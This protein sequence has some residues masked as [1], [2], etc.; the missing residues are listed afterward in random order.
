MRRLARLVATCLLMLTTPVAAE[1]FP[2][3]TA[4]TVWQSGNSIGAFRAWDRLFPTRKVARGD[5]IRELAEGVPVTVSDFGTGKVSK[6]FATYI[7]RAR[8]TGLIVLKDGAVRFEGYWHGATRESRFV[9]HSLAKSVVS[10]LIGVAIGD[11]LIRSTADPITDYLPELKGT[12]YADVPIAAILEMSSGV[13]FTEEYDMDS[14]ADRIW[15]DTVVDR[16]TPITD[17][18]KSRKRER[19]PFAKFNYA[20]IETAALGMLLRKVTGKSVSAYLSEKLW[21]PLGMEDDASWGLDGEAETASEAAWCCLSARLRDY[22]RLGQLMLDDGV[23]DG[24]RLLP[25]GW[26]AEST[27]PNHEQVRHGRLYPDYGLGYGYQWWLLPGEGGAFTGLGVNGQF[28]YVHPKERLVIVM[29]S[30]WRNF[31]NDKE[32]METYA[33]FEAFAKALK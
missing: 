1:E 31:W 19:E 17:W 11:G 18:V 22:A 28:L 6:P 23:L 30:A 12:G 25:G 29:T 9:S 27:R 32:E 3:G 26:V 15:T 4:E 16:R 20:G 21:Q 2:I 13:R 14:D 33:V 7:K 5:V 10:M 24:R 8:T